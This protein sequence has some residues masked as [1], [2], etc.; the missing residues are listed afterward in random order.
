MYDDNYNFENESATA[1]DFENFVKVKN[2]SKINS[3]NMAD[4]HLLIPGYCAVASENAEYSKLGQL[5][6]SQI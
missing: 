4:I 5:L 3:L 1:E 2:D 6:Q